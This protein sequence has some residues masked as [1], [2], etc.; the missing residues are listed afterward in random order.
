MQG[1]VKVTK[2][3]NTLQGTYNGQALLLDNKIYL[4][5][6]AASGKTLQFYNIEE[7]SWRMLP[8]APQYD[9]QAAV[10]GGLLTLIGGKDTSNASYT[11]MFSSWTEEQWKSIY[12]AMMCKRFRPGVV[13]QDNLTVVTG[14]LVENK[15]ELHSIEVFNSLTRQWSF[16]ETL[17]LPKPLFY[18]KMATCSDCIYIYDDWDKKVWYMPWRTFK[19][20]LNPEMTPMHRSRL[21]SPSSHYWESAQE[22][23]VKWSSLLPCSTHPLLVGGADKSLK[24]TALIYMYDSSRHIWMQ[25]GELS[26]AR[27][28]VTVVPINNRAFIVLGGYHIN[29]RQKVELY[30]F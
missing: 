12:P 27:S 19:E 6:D 16:V 17:K 22:A 13:S 4:Y 11:N 25:V 8:S 29:C 30:E 5:D 23:P 15:I 9:C 24:P 18:H 28:N 1:S 21:T 10:I 3:C 2:L 14:G 7:H 26:E 20:L